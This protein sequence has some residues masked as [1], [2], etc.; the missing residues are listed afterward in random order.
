[1][2]DALVAVDACLPCRLRLHVLLV[3]SLLLNVSAHSVKTVA[4]AAFARTTGLHPRPLVGRQ[5]HP[6]GFEFLL[7]VDSAGK[8]GPDFE[9]SFALADQF[10]CPLM[11]HMT[12]RADGAHTGAVAV[13]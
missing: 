3:D 11:G 13:V 12:I 4:I 9:R 7:G 2:R 8:L 1:M 5:A 10:V 6:V